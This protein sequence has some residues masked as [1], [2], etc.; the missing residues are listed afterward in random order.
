MFP[1]FLIFDEYSQISEIPQYILIQSQLS[2]RLFKY[3]CSVLMNTKLF[4]IQMAGDSF[5]SHI[6]A[7]L[8][9]KLYKKFTKMNKN[10][11]KQKKKKI[12]LW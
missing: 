10:T 4:L 8:R 5:G 12:K 9:E 1:N 2:E 7:Q 11:K 3:Y 6:A